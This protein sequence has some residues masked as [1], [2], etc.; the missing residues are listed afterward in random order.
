MPSSWGSSGIDDGITI[1]AIT[2]DLELVERPIDGD[3]NA[4]A[5]YD[6]GCYE[7]AETPGKKG[8]VIL[9]N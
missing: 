1:S 5:L 9:I 8:T 6:I 2:N 4:I 3:D 7:T